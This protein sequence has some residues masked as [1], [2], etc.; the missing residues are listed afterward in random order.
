M[1]GMF[2]PKC[3]LELVHKAWVE[4]RWRWFGENLGWDTLRDAKLVRPEDVPCAAKSRLDESD[5]NQIF[6]FIADSM[7]VDRERVC[8]RVLPDNEMPDGAVGLFE[9]RG[10]SSD[11]SDDPSKSHIFLAKSELQDPLSCV[12]SL[13]HEL[14]HEVLLG[15]GLQ[16]R[17]A[18]DME[19]TTDL[20]TAFL[21]YGL[22]VANNT[23]R[24]QSYS[25]G[26][27]SYFSISRKGY[28][29]SHV[30]GH[31]LALFAWLRAESDLD[32]VGLLRL[33]ARKQFKQSLNFFEKKGDV[34][35]SPDDMSDNRVQRGV[36]SE[37]SIN[38]MSPTHRLGKLWEMGDRFP[39]SPQTISISTQLLR[40]K[41]PEIRAQALGYFQN[42]S[43]I[44][45][46][47]VEALNEVLLTGDHNE[48]LTAALILNQHQ[49]A[50]PIA[51]DAIVH[52]LKYPDRDVAFYAALVMGQL[53]V[54]L[55]LPQDHS[56][57]AQ[58]VAIATE[59][60]LRSDDFEIA[61]NLHSVLKRIDGFPEMVKS[62]FSAWSEERIADLIRFWE[63]KPDS[64]GA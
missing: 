44:P 7:P 10:T 63:S 62:Q 30:F 37:F 5:A 22:F 45:E 59:K 51:Y 3:S 19:W 15:R 16:D 13:A 26:E 23:V 6:G 28:I 50:P 53:A 46:G 52:L 29:P 25:D 24:D 42:A 56:E 41:E 55:D 4:Y 2:A 61:E 17:N 12:S 34:L 58:N 14:A 1:F 60:A 47:S 49:L 48:T 9:L 43:Q 64:F 21:G 36:E 32:W 27:M 11:S 54:N 35:V 39:D 18:S 57:L 8:L 38:K 40:D 33:D 20:L 31:A